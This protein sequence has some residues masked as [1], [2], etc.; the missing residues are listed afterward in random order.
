[1]FEKSQRIGVPFIGN[2]GFCR[3]F[4][5]LFEEFFADK[6]YFRYWRAIPK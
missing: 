3:G 4:G 1:M 5:E 6:N 2:S